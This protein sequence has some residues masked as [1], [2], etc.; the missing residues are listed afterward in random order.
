MKKIE[1]INNQIT[2]SKCKETKEVRYFCKRPESNSYRGVCRKCS[3]GYELCFEDKQE[4]I[5][6]LFNVGLKECSKCKI[7]KTIDNFG[8]DKHT[9]FGV[10]SN[11]KMC[12]N[13]KPKHV[14]KN[15]SLKNK[16][17]ISLVDFKQM[18]A[19]QK[20]NCGICNT[21]LYTLDIKSVHTDH[22]HTTG[23][24]RGI[25]CKRCNF[26]LGW[27]KDDI[28]ILEQAIQYLKHYNND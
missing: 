11:C 28:V 18:I 8:L 7:I 17:N 14:I 25:L 22:C 16:Y 5:Q 9:K 20:G 26:G 13:S 27:F 2:C 4:K 10:A 12:I 6:Q 21:P 15:S 1:V 3:K 19:D 23:K 24:V